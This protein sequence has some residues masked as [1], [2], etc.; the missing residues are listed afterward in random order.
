M[1]IGIAVDLERRDA[2]GCGCDHSLAAGGLHEPRQPSLHAK[3]VDH[4]HPGVRDL[5]GVGRRRR[6]DVGVAIGADQ[7]RHADALGADIADEIGE[8]RKT[9]DHLDGLL[10]ARGGNGRQKHQ[11]NEME[12]PHRQASRWRPGNIWRTRPLTLPNSTETM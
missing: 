2:G 7:R 9:G 4:D 1:R 3:P 5:L 8:D 12:K 6:I 10:G 11:A